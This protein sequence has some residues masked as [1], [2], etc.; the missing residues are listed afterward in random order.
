MSIR[1]TFNEPTDWKQF[2]R[3]VG[4]IVLFSA[5][6]CV[7]GMVAIYIYWWISPFYIDQ[8]LMLWRVPNPT[9][10]VLLQG[11]VEGTV[12]GSVLCM[13]C[14]LIHGPSLVRPAK[15][16]VCGVIFVVLTAT[17]GAG[18]GFIHYLVDNK[19]IPIA[20]TSV[21]EVM[22]MY[23]VEKSTLGL[24]FGSMAWP[25]V[26]WWWER[27]QNGCPRTIWS[28]VSSEQSFHTPK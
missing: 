25:F 10:T 3:A 21:R 17:I 13:A 5:T 20:E 26:L 23:C 28:T 19:G 9:R 6:G 18:I 24:Y 2:A 22:A 4:D 1:I 16:V 14:Q 27:R 15:R 12:M 8:V 11:A 7:L